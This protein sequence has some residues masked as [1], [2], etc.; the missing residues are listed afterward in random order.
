MLRDLEE[1]QV[2]DTAD[3]D[4]GDRPSQ[5]KGVNVGKEDCGCYRLSPGL[6]ENLCR[7]LNR[8][9]MH[10]GRLYSKII[11]THDRHSIE[12]E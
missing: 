3:R 4:Y 10:S 11:L 1:G 8:A 12:F 5:K 6:G 7:P 2:A 9:V